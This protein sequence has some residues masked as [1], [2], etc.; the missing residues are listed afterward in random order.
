MVA[1]GNTTNEYQNGYKH[2]L[3]GELIP[4]NGPVHHTPAFE[5]GFIDGYCSTQVKGTHSGSDADW[6]TFDCDVDASYAKN[7]HDTK[8]TAP[9]GSTINTTITVV[10]L[11]LYSHLLILYYPR[12]LRSFS[13]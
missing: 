11:Q 9:P 4:E 13:G 2:G 1:Y 5:Q 7:G 8:I 6:G 3:A 12:W 10:W